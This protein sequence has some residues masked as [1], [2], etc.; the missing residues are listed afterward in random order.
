MPALNPSRGFWQEGRIRGLKQLPLSPP[1][2]VRPRLSFEVSS[3]DFSA[4]AGGGLDVRLGEQVKLRVIQ[5]DYA[6]IF[7]RN[8]S[9]NVLGSNGV[10]IPA[11]LEGKRQDN[12]RFGIGLV[13]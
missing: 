3:T 8:R 2:Q 5:V 4:A 10:I 9:I 13:F 12:F 11:T 6:P 1:V 7:L